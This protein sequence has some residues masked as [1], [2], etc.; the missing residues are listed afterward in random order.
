ME[1]SPLINKVFPNMDTSVNKQATS[2]NFIITT[3]KWDLQTS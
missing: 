2:S 3:K 1:E